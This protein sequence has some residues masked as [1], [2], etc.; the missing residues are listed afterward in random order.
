MGWGRERERDREIEREIER[1]RIKVNQIV[2]LQSTT[3][4][5]FSHTSHLKSVTFHL[6]KEHNI[7]VGA[8]ITITEKN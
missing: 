3:Y 4:E 1:E 6:K 5:E 2:L 7:C 8:V